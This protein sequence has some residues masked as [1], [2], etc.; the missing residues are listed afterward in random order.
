AKEMRVNNFINW[1]LHR[2]NG[3]LWYE[4]VDCRAFYQKWALIPVM[5][6]AKLLSVS[7]LFLGC[8]MNAENCCLSVRYEWHN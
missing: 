7:F 2:G 8:F 5:I 4:K 3:N 1:R 6:A